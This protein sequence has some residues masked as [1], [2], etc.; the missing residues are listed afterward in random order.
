MGNIGIGNVHDD[1]RITD[2][3]I[4]DPKEDIKHVRRKFKGNT[5]YRTF[6]P[7]IVKLFI[8]FFGILYVIFGDQLLNLF[9]GEKLNPQIVQSLDWGVVLLIFIGILGLQQLFKNLFNM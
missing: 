9:Y 3:S 7:A 5:R 4:R 2:L 8:G 1:N 6:K